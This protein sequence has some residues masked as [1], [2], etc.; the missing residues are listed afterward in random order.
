M[1]RLERVSLAGT[2]TSIIF[3]T[4]KIMFVATEIILVAAPANDKRE[5]EMIM[6][7]AG[8]CAT[9]TGHCSTTKFK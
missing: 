8:L 9:A 3:V 6:G 7:T 2:A 4:T 1:K 5:S